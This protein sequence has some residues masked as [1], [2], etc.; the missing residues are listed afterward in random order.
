MAHIRATIY[1]ILAEDGRTRRLLL[2]R[3]CVLAVVRSLVDQGLHVI[4]RH[5]AGG[6]QLISPDGD[7]ETVFPV[8]RHA[9]L[10]EGRP[11]VEGAMLAN[12]ALLGELTS[13]E[14]AKVCPETGML[15]NHVL[16]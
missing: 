8:Y 4:C 9:S 15:L 10:S 3:E 7:E 14:E 1:T 13:S 11:L 5:S 6:F 12:P 16:C 2:T